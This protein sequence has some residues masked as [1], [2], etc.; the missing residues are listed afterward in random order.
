MN[1]LE[2]I[3]KHTVKVYP[4]ER[5]YDTYKAC[6]L[7]S[8]YYNQI[9]WFNDTILYKGM[10]PKDFHDKYSGTKEFKELPLF[11]PMIIKVRQL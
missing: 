6:L 4:N 2:Y 11:N 7:G 10:T 3:E 1:A 8:I 9:G 5:C